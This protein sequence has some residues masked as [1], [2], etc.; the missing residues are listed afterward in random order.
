MDRIGSWRSGTTWGADAVV[1]N[2]ESR[3]RTAPSG[4]TRASSVGADAA[5]DADGSGE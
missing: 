4:V 1:R 5:G 2:R 3:Y